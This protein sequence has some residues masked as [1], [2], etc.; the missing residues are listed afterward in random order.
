MPERKSNSWDRGYVTTSSTLK[1]TDFVYFQ[2]VWPPWLF[3]KVPFRCNAGS[4]EALTMPSLYIVSSSKFCTPIW[5]HC[6]ISFLIIRFLIFSLYI[7]WL[8]LQPWLA[9]TLSTK[10]KRV[11]F[12]CH[13][14]SPVVNGTRCCHFPYFP[15]LIN[16]YTTEFAQVLKYAIDVTLHQLISSQ[17]YSSFFSIIF[18]YIQNSPVWY[19]IHFITSLLPVLTALTPMSRRSPTLSLFSAK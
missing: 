17:S 11:A 16:P 14:S 2:L 4:T 1:L 8:T 9:I 5:Y 13:L 6:H 19:R 15:P 10:S 18:Y 12:G 7:S 3:T